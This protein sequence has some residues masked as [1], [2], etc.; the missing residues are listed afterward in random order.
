[1]VAVFLNF[2][3]R[4]PGRFNHALARAGVLGRRIAMYCVVWIVAFAAAAPAGALEAG[5]DPLR[6]EGAAKGRADVR[7]GLSFRPS[8]LREAVVLGGVRVDRVRTGS[9]VGLEAG[10]TYHL[11]ERTALEL[12]TSVWRTAV[13]EVWRPSGSTDIIARAHAE[14]AGS[15]AALGLQVRLAPE[16]AIDPRLV[17]SVESG[18]AGRLAL[19]GAR[20]ADPLVTSLA[21]WSRVTPPSV[22]GVPVFDAGVGAAVGFVANDRVSLVLSVGYEAPVG[23]VGELHA[24]SVGLRWQWEAAAEPRREFAARTE[25]RQVGQ[26]ATVTFGIEWTGTF[27]PTRAQL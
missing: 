22:G 20:I 16:A 10:V 14:R 3:A 15:R 6:L 9:E 7:L 5:V 8:G 4:F 2:S 17:L 21:L 24:T 18:G 12:G 1:M 25:L 23:R 26:S 19:S 27:A 11:S 13:D